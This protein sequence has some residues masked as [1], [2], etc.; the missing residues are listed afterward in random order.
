[1]GPLL[2]LI[3]INDIVTGVGCN[4]RLFA[5]DTSL[6]IIVEHPDVAARCINIDLDIISD[7]AC[8]W[9]VKFSPPKIDSMLLSREINKPYYPP[10]FMS[11]VQIKDVTSHKHLGIHLSSDCTYIFVKYA[12]IYLMMPCIWTDRN[13]EYCIVRGIH[14]LVI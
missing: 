9:L 13:K 10:L 12:C 7:W 11:N 5:D 1:M 14:T 8:K 3:F 4:I 6:Y 2:F